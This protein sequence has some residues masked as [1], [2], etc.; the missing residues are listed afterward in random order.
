MNYEL[1][2]R[3]LADDN[4]LTFKRSRNMRQ[5]GTSQLSRRQLDVIDELCEG[6]MSEAKVLAKYGV[7][8]AIYRRWLSMGAFAEEMEFRIGAAR[9][10]SQLI[11]AKYAPAVA[12]KLIQLTES[13]KEETARK[14]C[15]DIIQ[16]PATVS[17]QY[18]KPEPS[19]NEINLTPETATRILEAL[20]KQT[21]GKT[22]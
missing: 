7:S 19:S 8:H 9:R 3:P 18:K 14:A 6:E 17:D 16:M 5:K 20:A 1:W 2:N 13:E 10:Q 11:M 22:K 15:L 4:F 21:K 12:A